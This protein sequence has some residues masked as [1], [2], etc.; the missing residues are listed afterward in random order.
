MRGN[1]HKAGGGGGLRK[2]T[3][4]SGRRIV[5]PA[6]TQAWI[7]PTNRHPMTSGMSSQPPCN[8]EAKRDTPGGYRPPGP[9]V[10]APGRCTM[11]GDRGVKLLVL[12][13]WWCARA[14]DRSGAGICGSSVGST[15]GQRHT[16][17]APPQR[18]L[19]AAR[20][21]CRRELHCSLTIMVVAVNSPPPP[22][23]FSPLAPTL[24]R[25]RGPRPERS[26]V[27][28]NQHHARSRLHLVACGATIPVASGKDFLRH[29]RCL[30]REGLHPAA[31]SA[32][33]QVLHRRAGHP[34]GG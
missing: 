2:T 32:T 28:Y 21:S 12:E 9:G 25:Y 31:H 11:G 26:P 1:L 29:Q 7:A 15:G 23:A 13:P 17:P 30:L 22:T 20:T 19:T 24:R 5:G 18:R 3:M 33:L 10:W 8:L 4:A 34:A 14:T 16:T 6:H 27:L